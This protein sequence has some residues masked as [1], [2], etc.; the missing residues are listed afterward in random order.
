MTNYIGVTDWTLDKIENP[1]I[2]SLAKN[3]GFNGV[4]ITFDIKNSNNSILNPRNQDIYLRESDKMD[5][6]VCSCAA[7]NFLKSPLA[8][9]KN[10]K[11]IIVDFFKVMN[12][13]GIEIMMIPFL[14]E[15]DINQKASLRGRLS[16]IKRL[17]EGKPSKRWMYDKSVTV[18]RDFAELAE[19][20][21]VTIGLETLL[22]GKNMREMIEKV[23]SPYIKVFFDPGNMYFMGYDPLKELQTIGLSNIC[24][25]HIK[26]QIKDQ[27][28]L[29]GKGAI[30]YNNFLS[31]LKNNNYSDWLV[32]EY[33]T[34]EEIGLEKSMKENLKYLH[35]KWI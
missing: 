14:Y 24:Q 25:I 10:P 21:S 15:G 17:V 2:F 33:S 7:L 35:S 3:M 34:N 8:L 5:V 29:I 1:S 23:K 12:D 20:Y 30:N 6:K 26:D 4:Q 11:K 27:K 31:W 19:K 28:A 9:E 16:E 13:L 32:V 22:P 18:L